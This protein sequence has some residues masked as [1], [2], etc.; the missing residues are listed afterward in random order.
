[1]IFYFLSVSTAVSWRNPYNWEH[2]QYVS[3]YSWNI[4]LDEDGARDCIIMLY[5]MYKV[6]YSKLYFIVNVHAH[7]Y[8]DH[9][10]VMGAKVPLFIEQKTFCLNWPYLIQ[11]YTQPQTPDSVPM[12]IHSNGLK[13]WCVVYIID[14]VLLLKSAQHVQSKRHNL[15]HTQLHQKRFKISPICLDVPCIHPCFR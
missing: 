1:M 9:I 2:I 5:Y 13:R 3:H 14:K 10:F 11:P 7:K 6:I 8:K 4:K 15:P 12:A